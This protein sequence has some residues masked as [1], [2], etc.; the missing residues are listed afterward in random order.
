MVLGFLEK[1]DSALNEIAQSFLDVGVDVTVQGVDDRI[2]PF[3]VAFLRTIFT[4]AL[5]IF[6]NK[7]PLP[8]SVLQQFSAINIVDSSVKS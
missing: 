4:Q 7:C 6:K 8:L 5:E 1:S 3:R 2:N